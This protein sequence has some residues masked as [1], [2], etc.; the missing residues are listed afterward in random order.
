MESCRHLTL[1]F[2]LRPRK[3]QEVL[4]YPS[5]NPFRCYHFLQLKEARVLL[6]GTEVATA[7]EEEEAILLLSSLSPAPMCVD[8]SRKWISPLFKT[9]FNWDTNATLSV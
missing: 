1:C 4:R 8:L 9:H 6:E 3:P 5:C 7:E 2:P